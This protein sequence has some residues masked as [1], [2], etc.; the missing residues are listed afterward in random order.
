VHVRLS[1]PGGVGAL[2][3]PSWDWNGD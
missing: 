1:S 2:R 3:P